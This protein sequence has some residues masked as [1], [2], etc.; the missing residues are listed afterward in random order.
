MRTRDGN[1]RNLLIEAAYHVL[2][3]NG[4]EAT[5]IKDIAR[6][7]GVSPGLVHYYFSN[8]EELLTA[9]VKEATD[10]YCNQMEQLQKSVVGDKLASAALAEPM[11][12]VRTHSDWYRLRYEMFVLGLRNEHI[13]PSVR[14]LL[15]KGREGVEETLQAIAG[16]SFDD[17]GE[18]SAILIACFDGLALQALMDPNFDLEKAYAVLREMGMGLLASK[19]ESLKKD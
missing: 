14:E 6:E 17:A 8:K 5:S 15:E 7:A 9:V 3:E 12:R 13:Q 4:Y 11:Q 18:L 10:E 2:A 1:T 16:S 19:V